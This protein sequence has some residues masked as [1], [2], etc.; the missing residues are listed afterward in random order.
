MLGGQH[1]AHGSRGEVVERAPGVDID[2]QALPGM[3]QQ[4]SLTLMTIVES[5]MEGA[6]QGYD[7]LPKPLVGM[8][9]PTLPSRHVVDPI[10]PFDVERHYLL[11]LRKGQ[12]PP[13]V[14]DLRQIDEFNL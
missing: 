5:D 3:V 4:D 14:S 2:E 10:G 8:T 12:I 13:R 11:S 9:S 7:E 6:A 1:Q